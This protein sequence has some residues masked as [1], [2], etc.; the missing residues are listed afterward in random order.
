MKNL[1]REEEKDCRCG[2]AEFVFI[3]Y[4]LEVWCFIILSRAGRMKRFVERKTPFP[5]TWVVFESARRGTMGEA[6][7]A[8]FRSP[9]GKQCFVCDW[10]SQGQHAMGNFLG[11]VK[12]NEG[13]TNILGIDVF[14][15]FCLTR[16]GSREK[17][18]QSVISWLEHLSSWQWTVHH[19]RYSLQLCE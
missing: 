10:I 5:F 16:N 2:L 14:K 6:R 18:K 7:L 19:N 11:H 15:F 12:K 8:I 9:M 4:Y 1:L 17:E 13:I 3:L